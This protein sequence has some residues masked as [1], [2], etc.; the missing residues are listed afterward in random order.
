[1]SF[2]FSTLSI[3]QIRKGRKV[4][5]WCVS[6][7]LLLTQ[8]QHRQGEVP[9]DNTADPSKTGHIN[10]CSDACASI[11]IVGGM[12]SQCSLEKAQVEGSSMRVWN[13]GTMGHS[14]RICVFVS[15]SRLVPK[16]ETLTNVNAQGRELFFVIQSLTPV[17]RFMKGNN[18]PIVDCRQ[19]IYPIY[20]NFRMREVLLPNEVVFTGFRNNN[21][22]VRLLS[23]SAKTMQCTGSMCNK[24]DLYRNGRM[25]SRCSCISSVLRMCPTTIVMQLQHQMNGG[26]EKML[27]NNFT[28]TWFV[29]N[30]VFTDRLAAHIRASHFSQDIED[31]ILDSTRRVFQY[32]NER[33]GFCI[34]VWAKRGMIRDQGAG[35]QEENQGQ[36]GGMGSRR[37]KPT[38]TTWS[39]TQKCNTIL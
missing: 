23:Y 6:S 8:A 22:T 14:W 24:Q 17:H 21:A 34:I 11:V 33:G 12:L 19:E 20:G 32:I 36:R 15:N 9:M 35:V 1:M 31:N 30:Y 38:T 5:T 39:K 4:N 28:S 7:L 25:E 27:I 16:D 37:T 10:E 18:H 2:H 3:I 29:K 13:R 26:R